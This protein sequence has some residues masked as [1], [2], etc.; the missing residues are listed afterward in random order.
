MLLKERSVIRAG[1]ARHYQ[2]SLTKPFSHT[3]ALRELGCGLIK[4]IEYDLLLTGTFLL[5][6]TRVDSLH[7]E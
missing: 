7:I 6:S 4:T 5:F 1:V 3:A 2:H